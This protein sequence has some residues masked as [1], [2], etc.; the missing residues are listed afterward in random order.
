MIKSLEEGFGVHMML[1]SDGNE[2]KNK[3]IQKKL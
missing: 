3:I 2:K 1:W